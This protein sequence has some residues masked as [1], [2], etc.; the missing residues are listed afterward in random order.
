MEIIVVIE[1]FALIGLIAYIMFGSKK[2]AISSNNNAPSASATPSRGE[3]GGGDFKS[4]LRKAENDLDKKRKEMEQL[5]V[6]L[7]ETKA[8]LKDARKKLHDDKETSKIDKDL[9]KARAEVEREASN[10][11]DA[12]RA[13]LAAALAEIQRLKTDEGKKDRR[14]PAPA[15][16]AEKAE[17]AVAPAAPAE[18]PVVQKVIRELS[19][20]DKEKMQRAE[21]TAAKDRAA[22]QDMEKDLR[23]ARN[24]SETL[25]RQVR[26][27]EKEIG[28]V[29]DKFR[30]LE[31]RTN[32]LLL[33]NEL[34]TR[35]LKDLEKKS[36]IEAGRLELSQDEIARSDQAVEAKQKAEAQAEAE[37][38]ARLEAADAAA[39][40]AT[41]AEQAP[42]APAVEAPKTPTA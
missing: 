10:Q 16:V 26:G 42:A 19:E 14:A 30:A 22:R 38:Q 17:A 36:G 18:K 1:T 25:S 29:Q 11:L 32:R 31:K 39:A 33:Q 40:A 12:T 37:A 5:K 28:L 41:S 2:P 3:D 6:E 21:A 15:P 4:Q 9:I 35:A 13:E 20:A 24:R 34:L 7:N 23:L 8:D 27:H